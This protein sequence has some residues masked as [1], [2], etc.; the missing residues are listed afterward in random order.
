MT[1]RDYTNYIR[2]W[3]SYVGQSCYPFDNQA[4][5]EPNRWHK[6]IGRVSID[7]SEWK[8]E[9][10]D[11]AKNIRPL[12]AGPEVFKNQEYNYDAIP[13]LGLTDTL[14]N[15]QIIENYPTLMKVVNY[16]NLKNDTVPYQGRRV[17]YQQTGQMFPMHLDRF[18]DS[19]SAE[20]APRVVRITMMLADWQPGQF[21]LYGNTVYS[22]WQAGD[23]HWFD[24][25]NT[26]HATANASRHPRPT[27]Q[28]TGL[29][30]PE[31]QKIIAESTKDTVHYI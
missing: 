3:D 13:D 14:I 12:K 9:L 28:M 8:D 10:A 17:H 22:Q 15:D 2:A 1:S 6:G 18:W 7:P 11:I 25:I 29:P 20:D 4:T 26:P 19:Y 27:L 16:F 21:I 24:W 30:S 23:I 31:M 5:D